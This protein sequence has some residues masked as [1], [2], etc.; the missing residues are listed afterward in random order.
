L[1]ALEG[2][3]FDV[4]DEIHVSLAKQS[5]WNAYAAAC[6]AIRCTVA[7][8]TDFVFARMTREMIS[9]LVELGLRAKGK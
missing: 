1:T 9:W 4:F 3:L 7:G 5:R 8:D 6:A 2:T